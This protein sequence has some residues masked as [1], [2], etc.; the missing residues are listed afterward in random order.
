MTSLSPLP[1]NFGVPLDSPLFFLCVAAAIGLVYLF[2]RQKF[3]ER[4]VTGNDDYVYQFLPRQLAAPQEYSKG[5]LIYFG[6]MVF[7][8]VLLSVIGPQNLRSLGIR[9]PEET[10]FVIV[11]LAVAFLLIGVLPIVPIL[12]EIEKWLR[13]YA[14]ERA[15]IPGAARAT[16]QRL[17]AADF[18][19]SAYTGDVLLSPEM[20]GVEPADFSRPRR[21]LEHGWARLSCL[22]YEEKS[23]RLSGV[24]ESLDA[25]L[26]RDYERDLENVED[27]RKSMEAEVAAYRAEK[28]KNPAYS[29]EALSNA[30]RSNLYKLCILLGC[31][32]R[33]K[34]QPHDDIDL[35]LRQFGFKLN[36]ATSSP[37]NGDLKLV[38]VSVMTLS[39]LVLGF[40]A[41]GAADLHLWRVSDFFPQVF[42]QPFIDTANTFVPHATAIMVADII[43]S[44]AI[45]KG[46]WFV[47]IGRQRR[48]ISANYVRV[49]VICGVAGYVG[50]IIWGLAFQQITANQLK[51]SA[52]FAL[53]AAVTGGFYAFHLDNVELDSRL[54]RLWE[55]GWQAVLT[56]ICG[57]VAATVSWEILLGDSLQALDHIILTTLT[58]ATVGFSLAWYI[59]NAAAAARIDPLVEARAE[60]IAMLE[61][62][63]RKRFG[64]PA[65][66]S[67][68]LDRP[69]P[70]LANRPPRA[71]A[72]D[73]EGYEQAVGLLQAPQAVAAA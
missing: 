25:G 36:Q 33:L 18:D 15:Y 16:A 12:Q 51:M 14:H 35:A 20:R 56:G 41:V 37:D 17:M 47:A 27:K 71:A 32:V 10:S 34:K 30:I 60:R 53:L 57:L 68:W 38:G 28:A 55:V 3:D 61:T 69:H 66:A 59:P 43:R 46:S 62:A 63:A 45:K 49:G 9:L 52:P 22:V 8:V 73:V 26:L 50:L 13:Q 11:P 39:V 2:C 23:R 44:H 48:A 4:S 21:S 24:F 40:A 42:Y 5:F 19:F 7:T 6:T 64:D 65:D 29:N 54:P 72:T 70:A 58:S 31:A 1:Q 67:A